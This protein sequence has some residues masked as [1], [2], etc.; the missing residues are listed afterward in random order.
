MSGTS[1]VHWICVG[2][3]ATQIK[4]CIKYV[5]QKK[6]MEAHHILDKLGPKIDLVSFFRFE[7]F[8]LLKY[9]SLLTKWFAVNSFGSY[10]ILKT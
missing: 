4:L 7:F 3:E 2:D 6:A 9:V 5:L 1:I 8:T 10:K